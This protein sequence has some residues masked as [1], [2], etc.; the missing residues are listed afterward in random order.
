[1]TLSSL[2]LPALLFVTAVL[3][4]PSETHQATLDQL[5]VSG[6]F[7]LQVPALDVDDDVGFV[8]GTGKEEDEDEDEDDC[9]PVLGLSRPLP[10]TSPTNLPPQTPPTPL[11]SPFFGSWRAKTSKSEVSQERMATR[12]ASRPAAARQGSRR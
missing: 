10:P 5:F 9:P 12:S 1:M 2:L 7:G 11:S 6:D 4:L 3:S 8:A